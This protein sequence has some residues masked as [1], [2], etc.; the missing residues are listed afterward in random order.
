MRQ[1]SL[2]HQT[3]P[4]SPRARIRA[5]AYGYARPHLEALETRELLSAVFLPGA[6]Q[7]AAQSSVNLTLDKALDIG[8]L[9]GSVKL[10]GTIN[11][12][13]TGGGA[14]DW[15]H[16]SVGAP[17]TVTMHELAIAGGVNSILS[18]YNT[19][20][21]NGP[22]NG[23]YID[24]PFSPPYDPVGHALVG[25][26]GPSN[27]SGA[28]DPQWNLTAGDYFLAV[29]GAGDSF[30]Y[31]YLAGSGYA[32]STGAY[33]L[34]ISSASLAVDPGPVSV[35]YQPPY[36][37]DGNFVRSG[38][39]SVFDDTWQTAQQLG[40]LTHT[41]LVQTVGSLGDP[42]GPAGTLSNPNAAV[43]LY[44]FQVTGNQPF[45]FIG[46][47]FA[48]RIGSTLDPGLSLFEMNTHG[49]FQLIA[50][51][52]NS[53]N[54]AVANDG[55]RPLFTDPVLYATLTAGD[56]YL[57]V[58]GTSNLPGSDPSAQSG[59]ATGIYD[60]N[61]TQSGQMGFTSG[62]YVLNVLVQPA[63]PAVQ[64]T[65]VATSTQIT[66][67][68]QSGAPL[69]SNSILS[70]P[71]TYLM[72]QFSGSLTQSQIALLNLDSRSQNCV[73]PIYIQDTAGDPLVLL[74]LAGYDSTTN[75]ATFLILGRL[76]SGD[77]T[78]HI[79]GS[80][81][82]ADTDPLHDYVL[83]FS[84]QDPGIS[85]NPTLPAGTEDLGI[86]FPDDLQGLGVPVKGT[87]N[88][89]VSG[90]DNSDYYQ[91]E[92]LQ[93]QTYQFSFAT[94]EPDLSFT[95]DGVTL[96]STN[97]IELAP[98]THVLGVVGA[99]LIST[100]YQFSITIQADNELT[101]PLTLGAAP[102]IQ[103][104]LNSTLTTT[105]PGG[106]ARTTIS[107]LNA[108][109]GSD[110]PPAVLQALATKPLSDFTTSQGAPAPHDA[111]DVVFV[112]APPFPGLQSFVKYA[113][114]SLDHDSVQTAEGL[115]DSGSE[116][117][118][119]P[120]VSRLGTTFRTW[121]S[122]AIIIVSPRELP[123]NATDSPAAP[124]LG[125][126]SQQQSAS[127]S[128]PGDEDSASYL[129]TE[130]P[131]GANWTLPQDCGGWLNRYV[132]LAVIV[133]VAMLSRLRLPSRKLPTL[134]LS[135]P[136]PSPTS[137]TSDDSTTEG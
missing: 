98:G 90:S 44:H 99:P 60:P 131:S 38:Y 132:A 55:T 96:P 28:T 124:S 40:D 102:A 51:N 116:K 12:E 36:A 105:S 9:G 110:I 34:Q 46:E 50:S 37:I 66:L 21:T 92:V 70:A 129:L 88:P 64:V 73:D 112:Q 89:Q 24:S 118:L 108:P 3:F 15:Y 77:Y 128:P 103:L 83:S 10:S 71:P 6:S 22:P 85:S 47:A 74:R 42:S 136:G 113:L 69:Q 120:F 18:L 115:A 35:G 11:N 1:R 43:D 19:D 133:I 29:S 16:F 91:F 17:T 94:S 25:Q 104:R 8:Q 2:K 75:Q 127:D 23:L 7:P 45:D 126:A 5:Q 53:F 14:V 72:V 76:R 111:F 84:I 119:A 86:L 39:T 100:S 67:P 63:Q 130:R 26:S 123:G 79:S 107:P 125:V 68:I 4:A 135:Q 109:P 80:L 30:F 56:Y 20:A 57:G 31:P 117:S 27:S 41:G 54:S 58:S 61:I 59:T 97:S 78:L 137:A 33:Q 121:I 93:N 106:Q 134:S 82:L 95:L 114:F 87:L 65:S 62:Y 49:V 13:P 52:D 81:G 101:P 32:G 122:E 48:G